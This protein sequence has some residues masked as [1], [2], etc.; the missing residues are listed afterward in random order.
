M[1]RIT[2]KEE[3]EAFLIGFRDKMNVF[4]VIFLNREK[5]L[6]A[7]LDL[8]MVPIKRREILEQLSA[9]DFYKGP[10]RDQE[11]GPDLWE[12]GV[13]VKKREVYVKVHMGHDSR[14]VI[15]VSFHIAERAIKYPFK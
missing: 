9:E 15:C 13:I 10:T 7:L 8:E 6:Q 5:N 12:F 11:N 1:V 2:K 3:V 14:P 4:D